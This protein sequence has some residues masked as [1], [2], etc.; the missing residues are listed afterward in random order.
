MTREK[1]ERKCID[2]LMNNMEH[3]GETEEI[4]EETKCASDDTLMDF[5]NEWERRKS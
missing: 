2:I 5:L 3:I 1:L 4:I